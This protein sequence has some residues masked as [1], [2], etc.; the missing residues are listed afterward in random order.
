[1]RRAVKSAGS[2]IPFLILWAFAPRPELFHLVAFS[3]AACG[4]IG[5]LRART[6]GVLA[7]GGAGLMA[8][9]DALRLWNDP[10]AAQLILS[11]QGPQLEASSVALLAAAT[12]LIPLCWGRAIV[13]YLRDR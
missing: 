1:M 7:M 4:L 2:T 9:V 8:L 6:W 11:P 13:R 3:L 10:S 5:L 12:L